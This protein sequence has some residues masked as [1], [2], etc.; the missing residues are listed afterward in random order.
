MKRVVVSLISTLIAIPVASAQTQSDAVVALHAVP[1]EPGTDPCVDGRS[2]RSSPCYDFN[3]RADLGEETWVYVIV[4]GGTN[5]GVGA[6]AFGLDYQASIGSG[7]EVVDWVACTD[8]EDADAL[9]P[10]PGS[11]IRLVW[12]LD[13]NC[14][15]E[16]APNSGIQALAGAFLIVGYGSGGFRVAAEPSFGS[17]QVADCNA[18]VS[19]LHD[20]AGGEI[21]F[22]DSDGYNPCF[23]AECVG[24]YCCNPSGACDGIESL[25]EV[26]NCSLSGGSVVFDCAECMPIPVN[27]NTWGRLKSRY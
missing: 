1:A 21:N 8:T 4:S 11:G 20:C 25:G 17:I 18:A 26:C 6:L 19:D 2:Y 7:L 24:C 5:P 14:Q 22:G 13:N 9:W 3:L 16:P 15:T 27:R 23:T 12:D 10:N